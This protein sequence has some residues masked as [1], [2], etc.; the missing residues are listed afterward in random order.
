MKWGRCGQEGGISEDSTD[1]VDGTLNARLET[2]AEVIIST[3]GGGLGAY[4]L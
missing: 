4:G 2:S 3:G 1:G